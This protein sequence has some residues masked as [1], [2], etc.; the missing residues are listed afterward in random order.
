VIN[1]ASKITILSKQKC[2]LK[3]ILYPPCSHPN[4]CL[5]AP[6]TYHQ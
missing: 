6:A 1:K 5:P 2:T 3:V 4:R